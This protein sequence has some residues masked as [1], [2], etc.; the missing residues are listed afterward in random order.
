[1]IFDAVFSSFFLL[2]F[3][4]ASKK[5]RIDRK[6]MVR[7]RVQ[8]TLKSWSVR[9]SR[10]RNFE[11]SMFRLSFIEKKWIIS[12]NCIQYDGD[13][14]EDFSCFMLKMIVR[15]LSIQS[16]CDFRIKLCCFIIYM[17]THTTH[18]HT[19][20]LIRWY[21]MVDQFESER[22]RSNPSGRNRNKK[23]RKLLH[24]F[25]CWFSWK[26]F[27]SLWCWWVRFPFRL[28]RWDN[29][30]RCRDA[31]ERFSIRSVSM[32]EK[33]RLKAKFFL[34]KIFKIEKIY[35]SRF[36]FISTIHSISRSHSPIWKWRSSWH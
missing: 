15:Y 12:I 17:H 18:T 3:F 16:S 30:E 6:T 22:Y 28:L 33:Y 7:N 20:T 24:S 27:F 23:L 34:Y 8:W 36:L 26:F 32:T 4:L 2:S 5:F 11:I 29:S 1:M 25:I 21:M 10:S 31:E 19:Q 35:L 9:W 13:G 14:D